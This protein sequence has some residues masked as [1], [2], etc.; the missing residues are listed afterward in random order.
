MSFFNKKEDVMSIQLTPYGRKLLSQGKLKPQ[1]YTFHD[2]DI[3]Y[4][5]QAA[6]VEESGT[7]AKTRILVDTPSL[8]PQTTLTGVESHIFNQNNREKYDNLL[9]PIGTNKNNSEKTNGWEATALMGEITSSTSH[10]VSSTKATYNIPQIECDM[11]YT[12][13][14]GNLDRDQ[15]SSEDYISSELAADGTFLKL[16]K[17]DFLFHIMEKNGFLHKDSLL[18]GVFKYEPDKQNFEKINFFNKPD[19]EVINDILQ[20]SNSEFDEF[21]VGDTSQVLD[22]NIVETYFE[23]LIDS[24]ISNRDLCKGIKK[25]KDKNIYLGIEIDCEEFDDEDLEINIYQ[26]LV[27]D[28]DIEDCEV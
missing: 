11:N 20:D 16:E 5:A 24:Q 12:M 27:T 15:Y 17:K 13:S 6:S 23:V 2:N 8:K 9:N 1:Y 22:E 3:L 21:A 25:L 26:T 18:L 7:D 14:V 19:N 28:D 4:D 10:I